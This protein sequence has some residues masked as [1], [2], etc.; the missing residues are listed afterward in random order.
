MQYKVYELFPEFGTNSILVW[1][2]V[3]NEAF[4]VD[5]GRQSDELI[6]DIAELELKV[7]FIVNTH[8]H[9][10]HIVGNDHYS[11]L[12]DCDIYIHKEDKDMLNS[13][14]LNLSAFMGK[15]IISPLANKM[16]KD[17][18]T[19]SIGKTDFKVIHTPGHTKGGIS[20]Y[21][22]DIVISGDTLFAGSIGR[23]DFPGGSKDDIVKSIH[24]KLFKLP[25]ETTVIPG[26]GPITIIKEEMLHN[27]F[28][29]LNNN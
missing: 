23:T 13:P 20:L 12:F 11:K 18:D 5:P 7:K 3:S 25:E 1:D 2:E 10:D 27:P 15:D 28:V 17:G 21:H 24:N 22:E 4:L 26:H 19:L 9:A 14:T 8:G 16:L 29:G 6:G